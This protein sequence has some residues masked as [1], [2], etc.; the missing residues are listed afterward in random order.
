MSLICLGQAAAPYNFMLITVL[1]KISFFRFQVSAWITCK[2]L[3][4]KQEQDNEMKA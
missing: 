1:V 3:A 2:C 4:N